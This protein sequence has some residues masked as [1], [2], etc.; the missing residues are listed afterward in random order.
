M[1]GKGFSLKRQPFAPP[2]LP[3]G[4]RIE[5][6][7]AGASS[8]RTLEGT[9]PPGFFTLQSVPKPGPL[10]HSGTPAILTVSKQSLLLACSL[11]S[12][13]L[14]SAH[15]FLNPLPTHA[16]LFLP[17]SWLAFHVIFSHPILLL[18]LI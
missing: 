5:G 14:F 2:H 3:K 11:S 1:Q 15:F 17:F 4:K 16:V 18:Y 9:K 13:T 6:E 7:T 12:L 8:F 10:D